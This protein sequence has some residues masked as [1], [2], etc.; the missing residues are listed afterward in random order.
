[1]KL[2]A[3][4][5]AQDWTLDLVEL[6]Q[7][8]LVSSLS[9]GRLN[10]FPFD[11]NSEF[12]PV[13]SVAAHSSSINQLKTPD[14]RNL[15]GTCASGDE[16]VKIFDLRVKDDKP[17]MTLGT[18]RH[19]PVLSLDFHG[20]LVAA[21]TELHNNTDAEIHI[22]DWRTGKKVKSLVD[23]HNDDITVLRFHP[24]YQ[25]NHLLL[26]GSTDGCVNVY[27]LQH[28]DE[29]DCLY[30]VVN[31]SSISQADWLPHNKIFTRSHMETFAIHRLNDA[32]ERDELTEITDFGDVRDKW[33]CEYV[34]NVY[35]GYVATGSHETSE[36]SII[37]FQNEQVDLGARVV[38]PSCH[39]GEV[40]RS[41]HIPARSK[42]VYTAGEDGYVRVWEHDRA[43]DFAQRFI[44][45]DE[46]IDSLKQDVD[47]LEVSSGQEK[48]SG[49]SKGG[50]GGKK[51]SSKASRD[52]FR[53]Y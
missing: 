24:E 48:P 9:N 41:V 17:I 20:D 23:S 21:G 1:M 51:K 47:G 33:N 7:H 11:R 38:I 49:A 31:F 8:G 44:P 10:I 39:T 19:I 32:T 28:E 37:P 36:V 15:V 42:L 29:D 52:R 6:E 27:D 4:Y 18:D 50:R 3:E 2:V 13:R 5:Q 34:I 30:Q 25:S 45:V 26:S 46:K 35:P 40:V 12:K 16:L 43:F 14:G 22:W 53:P